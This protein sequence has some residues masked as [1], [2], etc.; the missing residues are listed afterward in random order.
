MKQS[1]EGV[2]AN[3]ISVKRKVQLC[4]NGRCTAMP[5]T[6]VLSESTAD[7]CQHESKNNEPVAIWCFTKFLFPR[8]RTDF[9]LAATTHFFQVR[10]L[11]RRKKMKTRPKTFDFLV[12]LYFQMVWMLTGV[13]YVNTEM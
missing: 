4:A 13:L 6:L 10:V 11:S 8:D 12:C 9:F 1:D 5:A 3:Q 2:S 7:A